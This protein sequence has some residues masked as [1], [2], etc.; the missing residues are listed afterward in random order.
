MNLPNKAGTWQISY[1]EYDKYSET[2]ESLTVELE[3]YPLE[4]CGNILCFWAADLGIFLDTSD[5][6]DTDEWLGHIPVELLRLPNA[7]YTFLHP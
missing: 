3:V 4:P 6:W 1:E 5:F 2:T 7:K